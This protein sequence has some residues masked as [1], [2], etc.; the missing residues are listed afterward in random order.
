MVEDSEW[1]RCPAVDDVGGTSGGAGRVKLL[2]RRLLNDRRGETS[3]GVR[4]PV[5]VV[6][7]DR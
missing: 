5:G 6:P 1:G 7:A 3:S 4:G 2:A